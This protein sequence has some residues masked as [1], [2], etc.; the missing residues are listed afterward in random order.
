M[1][2]FMVNILICIIILAVLI[3]IFIWGKIILYDIVFCK[4]CHLTTNWQRNRITCFTIGK[5][6]LGYVLLL[7]EYYAVSYHQH[8]SALKRLKNPIKLYGE[9]TQKMWKK[10]YG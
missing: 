3:N 6:Y 10:T 9:L 5:S 4:L 1:P 8:Y 7:D 2:D